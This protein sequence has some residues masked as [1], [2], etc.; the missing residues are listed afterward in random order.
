[1]RD[2]ESLSILRY[3]VRNDRVSTMLPLL[4]DQN[5]Q[6]YDIIATQEPWRN[7]SI[8]ITLSSHQSRFHLLYRL[9]GDTRVC[10]YINDTI[11]PD[12]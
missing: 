9:N 7:P 5:T 10:F 4:A 6:D 11:D 3:N 12:S 8:P 2:T 1:M